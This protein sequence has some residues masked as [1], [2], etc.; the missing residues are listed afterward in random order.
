[1]AFYTHGRSVDKTNFVSEIQLK[2]LVRTSNSEPS[3]FTFC[4]AVSNCFSY[5]NEYWGKRNWK[6]FTEKFNYPHSINKG[7]IQEQINFRNVQ[8]NR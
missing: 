4:S 2:V 1:M 7:N 8:I 3:L 5:A 6:Y